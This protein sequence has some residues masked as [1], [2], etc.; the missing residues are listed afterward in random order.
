MATNIRHQLKELCSKNKVALT[1]VGAQCSDKV[2]KALLSG[3]FFNVAENVG[4]GKY[5]TVSP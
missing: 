4:E 2:R 1:S 3:L 5:Q